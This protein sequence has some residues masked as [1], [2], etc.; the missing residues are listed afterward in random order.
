MNVEGTGIVGLIVLILD[1][2][3]IVHT[4]H[5]GAS[6]GNKVLWIVVILLLPVIGLLLW[7]LLGPRGRQTVP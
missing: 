2:W 4:L 3:A 5:S 1:I 6:T 7:L